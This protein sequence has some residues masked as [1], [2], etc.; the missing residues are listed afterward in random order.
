MKIANSN[1]LLLPSLLTQSE[2]LSLSILGFLALVL[3]KN[4]E[5]KVWLERIL[6]P[7]YKT[8]DIRRNF[9]QKKEKNNY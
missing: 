6:L 4:T 9:N 3:I 8:P 1:L 5:I 2:G 7:A